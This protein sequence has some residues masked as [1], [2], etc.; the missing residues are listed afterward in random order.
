VQRLTFDSYLYK[1]VVAMNPWQQ[2]KLTF[3][4]LGA[5]LRGNALAPQSYKPVPSTVRSDDEVTAML[6]V[7]SIKG[8]INA[9]RDKRMAASIASSPASASGSET[10]SDEREPAGVA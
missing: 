7:S 3:L 2:L 4:T 6:A 8:G 5:V 1:R 9:S 10:K